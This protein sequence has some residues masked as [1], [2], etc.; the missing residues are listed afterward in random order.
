MNKAKCN[1]VRLIAGKGCKRKR[2]SEELSFKKSEPEYEVQRIV[3]HRIL[4]NDVHYLVKWRGLHKESNTWEP[5]Q[6][7]ANCKQILRNYLK[8]CKVLVSVFLVCCIP[9]VCINN[10]VVLKFNSQYKQH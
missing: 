1:G 3:V 6:N 5:E 9:A 8:K 7:L 10:K 2:V 4:E